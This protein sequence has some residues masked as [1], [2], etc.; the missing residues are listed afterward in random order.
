MGD[1]KEISFVP[2]MYSIMTEQKVLMSYLGDVTP[3]ITNILLKAIK[4][5]TSG[6]DANIVVR[7]KIY[8]IIVECLENIMRHS[9]VVEKKNDPS[10]FLLGKD[11]TKYYI[12]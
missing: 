6:F 9:E 10:I 8:K 12:I 3:P 5:D 2:Y 11:T 7:K 4:N 1:K